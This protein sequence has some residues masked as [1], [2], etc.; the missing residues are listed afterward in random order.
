MKADTLRNKIQKNLYH[1]NGNPVKC[2]DSII[3][4][5]RTNTK[6]YGKNGLLVENKNVNR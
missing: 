2:Y 6:Y 3:Y 4:L 1:K 5:I